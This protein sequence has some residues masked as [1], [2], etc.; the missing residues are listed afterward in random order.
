MMHRRCSG[1]RVCRV[2]SGHLE[3]I[4]VDFSS[5]SLQVAYEGESCRVGLLDSKTGNPVPGYGI[6][7]SSV[8]EDRGYHGATAWRRQGSGGDT[9]FRLRVELVKAGIFDFVLR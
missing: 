3:T 2:L 5:C 6:D 9:K 4:V 1:W 8:G 7:A